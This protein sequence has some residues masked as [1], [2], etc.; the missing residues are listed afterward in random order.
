M[1]F[2]AWKSIKRWFLILYLASECEFTFQHGFSQFP[3][4]LD[5]R[6]LQ[7]LLKRTNEQEEER[8][9]CFQIRILCSPHYMKQNLCKRLIS[10]TILSISYVC[11]AVFWSLDRS[12]K[13]CK[14]ICEIFFF[15]HLM[16]YLDCL[17]YYQC[18]VSFENPI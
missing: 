6:S 11:R 1:P 2:I 13:F 3:F 15:L 8:K 9:T 16:H 17:K 14:N 5:F 10:L 4:L 18:R 12:V 7:R